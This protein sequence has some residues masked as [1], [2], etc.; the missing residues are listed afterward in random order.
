MENTSICFRLNGE[1]DATFIYHQNE[2]TN[3]FWMGFGS[4]GGY[5]TFFL[6]NNPLQRKAVLLE[7][8][9]SLNEAVDEAM[10]ADDLAGL[11]AEAGEPELVGS[12]A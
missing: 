7:L 3:W 10:K 4:S 11:D 6:P 12:T 8:R 9:S 2:G 5:L 1:S